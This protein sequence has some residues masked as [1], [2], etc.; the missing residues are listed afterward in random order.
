MNRVQRHRGPDGAA[1][2]EDPAAAVALAHVRLAI[3][4]LTPAAAQPM[5]SEDGR[6]R[7]VYNGEIYNY[8]ELRAELADAGHTFRSTGDTEVLLA[9]LAHFGR[10][11]ICKLNGIFA[12]A[13]WDCAERRLLLARDPL[14]VKPLYYAEPGSGSL[15][16][17]S[18]IK[19]LCAHPELRREPDFVALQQHLAYGHAAGTRTALRGVSRLAAGHTLTWDGAR[20]DA[21][22]E[23]Y[24]RMPFGATCAHSRE[25]ARHR[26][27]EKLRGAVVRQL[28][29][30]VRVGTFLSGGIDSSL[31]TVLAAEALR[32]DL[33]CFTASF[34]AA[35]N[36]LDRVDPD[37]PHARALSR[38]LSIPLREVELGPSA[39]ASLPKLIFHLDEPLVDPAVI[40]CAAICGHARELGTKVLLSGQGGDELF[41]G[42]PRYLAMHLAQRLYSAPKGVRQV[43]EGV[44][45][46]LPTA[47]EGRIGALL[48]RA[49][50]ASAGMSETVEHHFLELCA[51]SP[52]REI[53]KVLSDD[54]A[55]VVA[56]TAYKAECLDY[57]AA[58]GLTGLHRLQ[59]RDLNIYMPN[60]NLLYTDKIGMAFGLEAR[61]PLLDLGVV[62]EVAPYPYDWQLAGWN[63][64]AL[65]RDAAR[66]IVPEPII[67]RKK[68]GFGA[69]YRTWLRY[70]L[71]ELWEEMSSPAVTQARG[72]F[73]WRAIRAARE[74]SQASHDDLYMLQ[75]GVL[76]LELWARQ[77]IDQNP[78]AER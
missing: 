14:G 21:A 13:L 17:A 34:A 77:F 50:R 10:D 3:L 15:V 78:A 46:A 74:R 49:R 8:R 60:H 66:G 76:T 39:V 7:L 48:R 62:N 72:W 20:R 69:P 24:W 63:T 6:Y 55:H 30:D 29:S 16:F 67:R 32:R 25:D 26:L 37:L 64:K 56:D 36:R 43:I 41:C 11:F 1:V 4:D 45:A 70:H 18:E 44:F 5:A 58:R 33:D 53:T 23:P 9:G 12:F 54:F 31:I 57:M 40:T 47:R 61:V 51:N 71:N 75:W 2:Y 68:A 73:D 19:A 59:D 22:V 42:Y 65:F 52:Q 35:D 38:T 28:V 27:R